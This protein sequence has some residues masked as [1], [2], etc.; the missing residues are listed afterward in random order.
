MYYMYCD[1]CIKNVHMSRSYF[2]YALCDQA[3]LLY[4]D[5]LENNY[6]GACMEFSHAPYLQYAC[7]SLHL[8]VSY[9]YSVQNHTN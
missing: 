3:R 4:G 6:N 8:V 9:P 1:G 2:K 5:Q 7:S